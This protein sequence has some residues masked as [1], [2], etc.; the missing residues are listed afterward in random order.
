MVGGVK[1]TAIESVIADVNRLVESGK[2]SRQQLEVRLEAEDLELL[3]QKLLPSVWYSLGAYGRMTQ[4]LYEAEGRGKLDYLHER[5]RR[6]ADRIRGAGLYA[7]LTAAR[8]RW[9]DSLGT[10][11]VTLGPAIYRDTDWAFR[12]LAGGTGLR[13]EIEIS[14]PESFPDVCRHTTQG[15]IQHAATHAAGQPVR[16][17]SERVSPTRIIFQ[18][19]T[20]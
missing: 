7:Q 19:V 9:G 4:L 5:G 17:S 10:M 14:V 15:F 12:L 2:I 3:E 8:E 13:F 11:M 6:A 18:G 16:M 20:T 1:G